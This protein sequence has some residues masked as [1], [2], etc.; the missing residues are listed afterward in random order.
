MISDYKKE[1]TGDKEKDIRNRI[2]IAS[3][4]LFMRYGFKSIT[5]DEISR[6]LGVSKKTL[7]Q[8]FEDKDDI[9]CQCIE[10]H[11]NCEKGDYS[12]ILEYAENP[13]H[14]LLMEIQQ[15]KMLTNTLHPSALFELR[16]YHPK[17]WQIFQEH[18]ENWIIKSVTDNLKKGIAMGLYRAEIEPEVLARLR[19][20]EVYIGFDPNIFPNGS[21][22]LKTIQLQFIEHFLY[23][24]LTDAGRQS[25]QQLL[26]K[27]E[28]TTI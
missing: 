15:F 14:E 27:Y 26:Q 19:V 3:E 22:Q 18:K 7:Y 13:I 17:A 5:M 6:H 25:L 20:E 16:K 2:L 21:F 1:E 9:V 24:I 23:G 8:Y 12:K 11:L 10:N 4:E 28:N